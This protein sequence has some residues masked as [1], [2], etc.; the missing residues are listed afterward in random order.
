MEPSDHPVQACAT[1]MI[2]RRNCL[3]VMAAPLVSTW[4]QGIASR[5][6]KPTPRGKPTGLPF[7]ARFTD[8]GRETGLTA[9]VIYGGVDRKQYILETIGCGVA[10]ID[11]DN[12]GWLDIFLLSGSRL[13]SPPP[14]ARNRLLK[15]NRNGTF[16]DVTEEA[17]LKRTG[18]AS[19]VAVGDFN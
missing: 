7:H 13:Q 18:W 5:G 8:V 2:T 16:S 12:D 9:P 10:L 15:N 4:G 19:A 14:G 6:V 1:P 17:G 3:G 11:Y